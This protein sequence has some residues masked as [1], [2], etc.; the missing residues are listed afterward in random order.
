MTSAST[1]HEIYIQAAAAML[2][3]AVDEA[4][5]AS[6]DFNLATILKHGLFVAAFVLPDELEPAPVFGA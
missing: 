6:V 2:G 4:W 1:D 5:M 3:I